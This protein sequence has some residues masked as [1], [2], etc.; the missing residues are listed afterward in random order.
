MSNNKSTLLIEEEIL[1]LINKST[2]LTEEEILALIA[3][4][5]DW[6]DDG[7]MGTDEHYIQISHHSTADE[8]KKAALE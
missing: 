4:S 2:P 5:D 8:V 3:D 7:V 1:S 6:E